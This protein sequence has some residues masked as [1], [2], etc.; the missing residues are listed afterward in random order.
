MK[1]DMNIVIV[2]HVDHGKSTLMGR[3]LADTNSLPE[4][5]L[6]QVRE[7]CRRNSKPF[8]YAFLLDALK[9]EQA[10]GITIDTARC[11]FK[12][13][14]RDYI[15]LDAPGHIEFL[16]NMI[17]GA[18][19]AEAAVLVIDAKEGVRE[20]SK[21]HG[22]ML[23][24]LGIKQV[25]VAINKMD[26]VEYQEEV[27][28]SVKQEY[29]EFLNKI[30]ITPMKVIPIS[31]FNGDNVADKSN[32][33][34]WYGGETILEAL[35]EFVCMKT[36]SK[37]VFR[38]PVQDVYK[39][40]KD[41]DDRRIVAGTIS[42]GTIHV[43]DRVVFYP[44]GKK[45]TVK[46]IEGFPD[47]TYD[48][49]TVNQA[50]GVTLEEQ[51]YIK[52]G[53]IMTVD[54]TYPP[55]TA[56]RFKANIFWLGLE[57]MPE[58]KEYILKIGTQKVK[59]I[60]EEI[61]NVMNSSDLTTDKRKYIACNEVAECIFRTDKPVAFDLME[62]LAETSR[63]VIVDNYEISGGGIIISEVEDSK[64]QMRQK[65]MLRNYKWESS[66]ISM[67]QRAQ[68][69]G[70]KP[71]LV[72]ITGKQHVGKK[73]LAKAL[74]KNLLESGRV[75]YYLGIG[76]FLYGVDSDIKNKENENHEE[77]IRRFAEV[78]NLMLDSGMIL[79]VT[80]RSLSKEDMEIMKTVVSGD[81]EVI[82][83]GDN[84]TDNT[85]VDMQIPDGRNPDAVVDIK[86]MLVEKKYMF[87]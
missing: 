35:D 48:S 60:V 1:E 24:M 76:T 29:I 40:T 33:M 53:E 28:E 50:T 30:G 80:A 31:A 79:V 15:I 82:W 46:S 57:N 23:S 73:E 13:E 26:L 69:Y 85:R 54:G 81:V 38:M 51:I 37:A 6:E 16:K 58:G 77:H 42:S 32:N 2:G 27:F 68:I 7:K 36:D 21:R 17:T 78:A 43:G 65:V 9:D 19:R 52:R 63:F 34:P 44:S 83:V 11:F 39:F 87:G 18:A 14:K 84:D 12:T 66:D 62:T 56:T 74:E 4:G 75:A 45:S 20:N 41:G 22:Y 25:V 86:R 72:V 8:E 70:Q 3:L 71:V 61:L 5:K 10:Q 64:S 55:K 59:V 67:E 47:K 49:A